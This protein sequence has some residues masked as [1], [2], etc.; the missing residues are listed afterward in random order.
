MLRHNRA[1]L[2]VEPP[3]SPTPIP[4]EPCDDLH[5]LPTQRSLPVSVS[6]QSPAPARTTRSK[7]I[8]EALPTPETVKPSSSTHSPYGREYKKVERMDVWFLKSNDTNAYN[9]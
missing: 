5:P 4:L 9:D 7:N 1:H 8:A 2:I 6:P 3:G